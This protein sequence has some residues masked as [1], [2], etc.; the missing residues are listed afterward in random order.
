MRRQCCDG[1]YNGAAADDCSG[2]GFWRAGRY[3]LTVSGSV[4]PANNS[5]KLSCLAL[6]LNQLSQSS[7][8]LDSVLTCSSFF[9]EKLYQLDC[10]DD[11]KF[12][13]SKSTETQAAG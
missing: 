10:V 11:L 5:L 7:A 8:S 13:R 3:L 1:V 2:T 12:H 9:V 6:L 4:R